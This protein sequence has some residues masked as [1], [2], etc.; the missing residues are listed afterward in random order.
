[1]KRF[2]GEKPIVVHSNTTPAD[3]RMS[4]PFDRLILP[5]ARPYL[6]RL[7]NLANLVICVS[8]FARDSLEDLGVTARMTELPHGVD[9]SVMKYSKDKGERFRRRFGLREDAHV[10]LS[11]GHLILRKGIETF[12][13]IAKKLPDVNFFWIGPFLISLSSEIRSL[14]NNR[15]KTLSSPDT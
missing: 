12:S 9:L 8:S 10:V 6:K 2:K 13:N 3:I 15:P 5:M 1:M 11:V 14:I 7:Y 4:V